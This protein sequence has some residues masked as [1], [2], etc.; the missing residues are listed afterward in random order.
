M[1]FWVVV[2]EAFGVLVYVFEELDEVVVG[3]V[4]AVEGVFLILSVLG[5][6][7]PIYFSTEHF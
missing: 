7:G 1:L 6:G 3:V 5:D 4:E 2:E